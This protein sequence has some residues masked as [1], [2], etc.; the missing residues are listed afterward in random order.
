MRDVGGVAEAVVVLVAA[1]EVPIGPAAQPEPC[2]PFAKW[3]DAEEQVGDAHTVYAVVPGAGVGGHHA[4][5]RLANVA[6]VVLVV[7]VEAGDGELDALGGEVDG[8]A[9]RAKTAVERAAAAEGVLGGGEEAEEGGA[10]MAA[11]EV[12]EGLPLGLTE[13]G[14][15]AA[16]VDALEE[17]V[18][19]LDGTAASKRTVAAQV[20]VGGA[21]ATTTTAAAIGFVMALVMADVVAAFVIA[22]VDDDGFWLR[23]R[24][25][26]HGRRWGFGKG[27]T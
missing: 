11:D 5:P 18:E 21:I 25:A 26:G 2:G 16:V 7:E 19:A 24:L 3:L 20:I 1:A 27:G 8:E 22:A 4:Q 14:A 23:R 10:E 6:H 13:G 15:D 12:D 17:G 9:V